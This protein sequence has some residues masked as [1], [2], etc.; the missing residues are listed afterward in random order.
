MEIKV[1]VGFDKEAVSILNKLIG[2]LEN[3]K[4]FVVP[5]IKEVPAA[6][7]EL[8]FISQAGKEKNND[9]VEADSPKT[10]AE[11]PISVPVAESKPVPVSTPTYSLADLQKA[12]GELVNNGKMEVLQATLKEFGVA[13]LTML[14]TEKYGEFALKLRELGGNI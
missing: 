9:L 11:K 1:T 5:E 13:A 4:K 7:K 6:K 14:P 8:D 2:V 3:G 12:A 10:T